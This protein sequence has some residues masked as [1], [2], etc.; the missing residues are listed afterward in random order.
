MY[1]LTLN[2]NKFHKNYMTYV[3]R[4]LDSLK[5]DPDECF[6]GNKMHFNSICYEDDIA[7]V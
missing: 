1:G 4:I 3:T 2:Y 5:H 7:V 6:A